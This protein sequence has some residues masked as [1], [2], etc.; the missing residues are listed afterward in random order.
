MGGGAAPVVVRC[1]RAH[2]ARS[3]A[4]GANGTRCRYS[5]VGL[6]GGSGVL[7]TTWASTL[8]L[9]QKKVL[10]GV[11]RAFSRLGITGTQFGHGAV[12]H[13]LGQAA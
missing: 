1:G 10:D 11:A 12:Q 2:R 8:L 5:L 6:V 4:V 3:K 9:A 7:A 13:L